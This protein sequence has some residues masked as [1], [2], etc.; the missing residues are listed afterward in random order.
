MLTLNG[1]TSV[2]L[3]TGPIIGLQLCLPVAHTEAFGNLSFNNHEGQRLTV[4][5]D[6]ATTLAIAEAMAEILPGVPD[7]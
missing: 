6:P 3:P 7:N 2:N 1:M 4:L 5:L